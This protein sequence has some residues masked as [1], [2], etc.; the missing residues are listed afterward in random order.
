MPISRRDFLKLS[1]LTAGAVAGHALFAH[2]LVARAMATVVPNR[3]FVV[4]F[5]DGGNDGLNTITPITN[6]GGDLRTGYEAARRTGNGGLQLATAELLPLTIAGRVGRD[7]NTGAELGMHPG[8]AGQGIAGIGDG[9]LHSLWQDGRVAVVQGCGYPAYSLS[10]E[11]SETIMQ[12]ANPFGLQQSSGSG[13]MG[14]YFAGAFGANDAVA[15]TVGSGVHVAGEFVNPATSV[16]A[17]DDLDSFDFP[18]DPSER[19]NPSFAAA[20]RQAF[21]D[22]C[23]GARTESPYASIADA[24]RTT[25]V[26]AESYHALPNTPRH[27]DYHALDTGVADGF[28]EIAR[29]IQAAEAGAPNVNVRFFQ[30]STGGYDTHSNQGAAQSGSWHRT[31]HGRVGSALRNFFDDLD[32]IGPGIADRVTVFVWSEF[33]RRVIQ[34]ENGSDHGSQGPMFVVGGG[35]NGGVYGNH[36]NIA[37]AALDDN[38]NSV[39]SQTG[40]F[41]S[42]DIRDVYG[43]ILKHWIGVPAATVATMLPADSQGGLPASA[44]WAAPNFDL[45]RGHDAAP[46]FA[47]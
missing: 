15:A 17:L 33:A 23:A 12:F 39:Y 47:V 29:V 40:A 10:H 13:W 45:T 38:G 41:R 34:N 26:S 6:G 27:D 7:P 5:L 20:R 31:L 14:R 1:G 30:L 28:A 21:L 4:L 3:Y 9:G 8:L 25:L 42:T 32:A 24:G 16:L 18:Y 46:L 11:R 2:P 44:Q 22:L 37:E 43:T 35:V 19:W 36:P